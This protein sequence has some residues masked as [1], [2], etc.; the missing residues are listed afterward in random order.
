MVREL[1]Y[2]TRELYW[3]EIYAISFLK[4][5]HFFRIFAKILI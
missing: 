4:I 3:K 1:F 5:L 2:S